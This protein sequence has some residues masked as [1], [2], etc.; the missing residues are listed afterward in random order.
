MRITLCLVGFDEVTKRQ[1]AQALAD[2]EVPAGHEPFQLRHAAGPE[3]V[4]EGE[5]TLK[6]EGDFGDGYLVY[7]FYASRDTYDDG[8]PD[9][10]FEG[11]PEPAELYAEIDRH[12]SHA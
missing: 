7:S 5:F 8:V 2:A 10:T 4:G 1:L 12:R 3:G 11:L 9:Q 6:A